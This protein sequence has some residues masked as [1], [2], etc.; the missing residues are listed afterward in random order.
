MIFFKS[1]WQLLALTAVVFAHWQMPIVVPLKILVVLLHEMSHAL[2][3]WLT[4]GSVEQ[5]SISA[6]QGGFYLRSKAGLR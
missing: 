2:A 1:H 6:Q 5:I 4:G 3:A